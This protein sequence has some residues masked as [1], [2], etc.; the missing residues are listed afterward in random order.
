MDAAA[1]LFFRQIGQDALDLV[2]PG[3]RSWGEMHVPARPPG[4]PVADRLGL[5]AGYVVHDDMDIVVRGDIAAR[6]ASAGG[7]DCPLPVAMAICHCR[8]R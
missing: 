8:S 1:D 7:L 3:G 6:S 4:E 2:D 5:M